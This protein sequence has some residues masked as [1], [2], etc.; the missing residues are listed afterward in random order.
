MVS[1]RALRLISSGVSRPDLPGWGG[2]QVTFG[3][4]RFHLE[5]RVLV[6]GN[7]PVRLGSRAREILLAL[8]ERP[9]QVVKKGELLARV[10]PDTV[11][12]ESALRVHIA[13]LRKA[14][15]DG[16]DGLRY[17][18]NV[19]GRGYRFI[20]PVTRGQ[21]TGAAARVTVQDGA[22]KP[23]EA[24]SSVPSGRPGHLLQLPACL[25]RVIGRD[26]AIAGV[27]AQLLSER[28]VTIT[29][30][31]G[32][33]KTT[34]AIAVAHA[35]SWAFANDIVFFDLGAISGSSL[36]ASTLAS[37]FGLAVPDCDPVPSL[38]AFLR[39]RRVLLVL[40]NCEHLIEAVA[41]LASK[42]TRV[43]PQAHILAT[44][45]EALRVEGEHVHALPPLGFP[46]VG[47][48]VSAS[49]AL[50]YPAIQLFIERATANG[51]RFDLSDAD[52]QIVASL[53]R[54][55]DGL[56][57]GVELAAS[58]VTAFGIGGTAELLDARLTFPWQ[59]QRSAPRRH[60]TL[61]A[62]LDW[63]YNLLT[64]V[65]QCVL[66]KLS[67]FMEPFTLEAAQAIAP[68]SEASS[69]DVVS[70]VANLVDK[71]LLSATTHYSRMRYRLLETTRAYASAK[72]VQNNEVDAVSARHARYFASFFGSPE[73]VPTH[74]TTTQSLG[75][76]RAALEWSF[77]EHGDAELGIDLVLAV[78][79]V[80]LQ[81]SLLAEC[82]RW[83]E[84]AIARLHH[85]SRGT[86][87]EL[88]LLESLA[89]STM[90]TRGNDEEVRAAIQ[91]G[92]ALART[93][94]NTTREM[95]LL[96]GLRIY[97][98]RMGDFAGALDAAKTHAAVAHAATD[99]YRTTVSEWMLGIAHHLVGNQALAQEHCQ[100]G[101]AN[102]TTPHHRQRSVFGHDQRVRALV[103]LSRTLWLRGFAQQAAQVAR[104]AIE[105]AA[106]IDQPVTVCIS[107]I[108]TASVYLWSGDVTAADRGISQ[109]IQQAH[110]YSLSPYH[111]VGI[112]LLGELMLAQGECEAGIKL[113]KDALEPLDVGH[114]LIQAPEF[115][116]QLAEGLVAQGQY[117]HALASI[118]HAAALRARS[119]ASYDM[120]EIL[121]VK[122]R[123]LLAS[124]P[125]DPAGPQYL[126]RSL[127]L[128]QSQSSLAW[129]L[130]TALTCVQLTPEA[131]HVRE[132]LE[133]IYVRFTEGFDTQDLQTAR[134]FLAASAVAPL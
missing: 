134:R 67:V 120:P 66:R 133:Q 36:I 57:L 61:E 115:A 56:A 2:P 118:E 100:T 124:S 6:R 117:A 91:R 80:L 18:Q 28:L 65:E 106:K 129:A 37:A 7:A 25:A 1:P 121:R 94:D 130:R 60:Q 51:S 39:S 126:R 132:T 49:D 31:G 22:A 62:L 93:L 110:D 9:G 47:S 84:R 76:A 32:I 95:E 38:L 73:S 97:L 5:Q 123:I 109:L 29:G 13:A 89:I 107:L 46:S 12:D 8:V 63:S 48:P 11:V 27:S 87:R 112:G 98:T 88:D 14:L 128:A 68:E 21:G 72:L 4:F 74:S 3:R 30:P 26:D 71:S 42:I 44:S 45:R 86:L 23:P 24:S 77:S 75:D 64:E 85:K 33:G 55:V 92:L 111:A 114:H 34:V 81:L 35:V 125:A 59:A 99:P 54:R 43:V 53:C 52:A 131:P 70:I 40:D 101:L 90:F 108:Y 102:H 41:A 15:H 122:G 20:A 69:T 105:E 17:V 58:R 113:L 50:T 83:S 82:R 127:D 79:P 16:E 119:G 78:T 96:V 116:T 19:T 10:W 103:A 104:E